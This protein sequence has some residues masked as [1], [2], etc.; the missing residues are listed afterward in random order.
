MAAQALPPQAQ[1]IYE[2]MAEWIRRPE[3]ADILDDI[4]QDVVWVDGIAHEVA[5]LTKHL[6]GEQG[7]AEFDAELAMLAGEDA[8]GIASL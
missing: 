2:G 7:Q 1:Q 8:D 5:Y 4:A 6:L 3:L